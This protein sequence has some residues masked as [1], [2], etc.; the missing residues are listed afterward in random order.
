MS[1]RDEVLGRVRDALSDR[2][3]VD[4]PDVPRLW[5]ETNPTSEEMLDRFATEFAALEGELI[6]CADMNA[7]RAEFGKLLDSLAS[8]TNAEGGIA[9][10]AAR[11]GAI[12]RPLVRELLEGSSIKTI[13]WGE[14]ERT[15]EA[16]VDLPLAV[17]EAEHLLADTGTCMMIGE[18]VHARLMCYLPPLCCIVTT[19]DRLRADMGVVW[20]D[21]TKQTQDADRR[22]E[23]VFMSGP[24]RTADIEKILILGVHGPKRV[25]L[26]LIG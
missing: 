19:V 15:P 13:E 23:F 25:V 3:M 5:P 24:S 7:A 20:P 16:L 1:S 6:R 12:Q 10:A 14:P 2:P 21:V 26:L 8:E 18:T 4:L 9:D 11:I 17:V 22:G